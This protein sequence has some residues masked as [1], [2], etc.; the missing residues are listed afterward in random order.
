MF[1]VL[2]SKPPLHSADRPPYTLP[3]YL[4]RCRAAARLARPHNSAKPGPLV[5]LHFDKNPTLTVRVG[6]AKFFVVPYSELPFHSASGH[7]YTAPT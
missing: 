6:P 2:F 3:N 5:N 4:D 1:V 7:P